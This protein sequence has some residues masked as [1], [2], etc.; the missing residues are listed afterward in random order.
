MKLHKRNRY[1]NAKLRRSIGKLTIIEK[2]V[3]SKINKMEK[4]SFV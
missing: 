4:K 3:W 2:E 1:L